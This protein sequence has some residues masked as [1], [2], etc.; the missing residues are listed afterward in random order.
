MTSRIDRLVRR[1]LAITALAVTVCGPAFAQFADTIA[2]RLAT[3]SL[4]PIA[5]DA[6]VVVD[7]LDDTD[8]NLRVQRALVDSLNDQGRAAMA[9]PDSISA[10]IL[11]F[12]TAEIIGGEGGDGAIG[13]LQV[14]T[15]L[16]V[17]M[18]LNLWSSTRDALI[19]GRSP[20][21][22]RSTR[23]LRLDL[24]ARRRI[25]GR[26]VWH[27]QAFFEGPA[28]DP[29]PLFVRMAPVLSRHF[30]ETTDVTAFTLGP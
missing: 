26:V 8:A 10:I 25:D 22:V 15:L 23:L 7:I 17:Q 5:A 14:D 16:G 11:E 20:N 13:E 2:G 28:G 1:T 24:V 3:Q 27:G 12:D 21:A 29:G 18:R 6:G 9:V 19:S 4:Q 30:G